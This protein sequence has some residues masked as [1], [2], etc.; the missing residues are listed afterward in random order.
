[1]VNFNCISNWIFNKK[2]VIDTTNYYVD[3]FTT[4]VNQNNNINNFNTN[5]VERETNIDNSMN[6]IN[7]IYFNDT[8]SVYDDL[9]IE[10]IEDDISNEMEY[11][12][13]VEYYHNSIESNNTGNNFLVSPR[14]II[15]NKNDYKCCICLESLCLKN[16]IK[17]NICKHEVHI[18][19]IKKWFKDNKYC[20]LCRSEQKKI[21]DRLNIR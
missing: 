10:N 16:T 12:N 3:N 11:F 21:C 7:N 18:S 1:M 14:P 20:P 4:N 5:H 9:I 15:K 17:L 8:T 2:P 13:N 6:N 19:C